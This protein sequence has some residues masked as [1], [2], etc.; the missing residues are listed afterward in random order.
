MVITLRTTVLS[1]LSATAVGLS[2]WSIFLSSQTPVVTAQSAPDQPDAFMEEIVATIMNKQGTPKLKIETPKMVH[3]A[4]D[5]TTEL[6]KPHVV[7]YRQSP[8]P[9]HIHANHAKA[10]LGTTEIKFWENVIIHHLADEENPLTTMHTAALTILPEEK[11]AKTAEAVTMR[12]PNAKI[13]AV[14]MLANWEEGTVKLLSQAKEEYVP[15][16]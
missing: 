1:L 13:D 11:V 5:D 12:Q 10:T 14:G 16:S 15:N 3:Y 8:Q 2:C 9:W 7:I 4:N 6:T